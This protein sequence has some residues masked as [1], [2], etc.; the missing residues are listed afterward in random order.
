MRMVNLGDVF[1]N[2][3]QAFIRTRESA[4]IFQLYSLAK[5]GYYHVRCDALGTFFGRRLY[6]D[7]NLSELL[8]WDMDFLFVKIPVNDLYIFQENGQTSVH[9]R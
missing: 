5:N 3:S 8:L 1:L 9:Q 6:R 2:G 7:L 4:K